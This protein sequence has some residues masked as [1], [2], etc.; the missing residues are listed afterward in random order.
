MI[1]RLKPRSRRN[2]RAFLVRT[3]VVL[4]VFLLLSNVAFVAA[5]A[6][7][8]PSELMRTA[9]GGSQFMSNTDWFL[10]LRT[11]AVIPS[12]GI[13]IIVFV[14]LALGHFFV[15]GAK[16][17]SIRDESDAIPWWSATERVLHAIIAVAFVIL[18]IS[19]LLIT[20]GRY[21]GGGT[22]TL[23][24]RL[25]HE[26]SGFVFTPVMVILALMWLR[27]GLFR[28]YDGEWFTKAG[29]Y[30]GYKGNLRSGKFNAGQKIWYWFMVV[31]G[32]LLAWSGFFL[33]FKLGGMQDMRFYQVLH[34]AASVPIILMFV[35]HLYMTTIGVK[36]AFMG[37][38]NG[39]FSKSA[40]TNYHPEAPEMKAPA[41][42]AAQPAGAD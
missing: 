26:Y 6:V 32:I 2:T 20:F 30:L 7:T 21:V 18:F 31:F 23:Y 15:F 14:V 34:F 28:K 12:F 9:I 11:S 35:V 29:G 4:G 1:M 10:A 40:A 3:A 16:D 41:Q 39:R 13:A 36:G 19:G 8:N 22:A 17:M 33:F 25:A 42:P 27:H 24:M 38:I 5:Q 37:M